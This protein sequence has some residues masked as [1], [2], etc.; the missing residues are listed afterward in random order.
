[1][2]TGGGSGIGL[3]LARHFASLNWD[4]AICG[5]DEKTLKSSA[6]LLMK[7]FRVEC[8]WEVA[9]VSHELEMQHFANSVE[10]K[11]G[12]VDLVV[13][14]AAV[15]GPIGGLIDI[16]LDELRKA[17]E[18][19]VIGQMITIRSFWSAM[20]VAA[21]PRAIVVSGGGL[22]ANSQLNNALGYVPSKAALAIVVELL[23]PEFKGIDGAIVSVAPSGVIPTNFLKGVKDVGKELAGELLFEQSVQ[24][25]SGSIDELLVGFESLIEFLTTEEG[26]TFNGRLLS[27]KWNPVSELIV[28]AQNGIGESRY[29]LRRIDEQLFGS[30]S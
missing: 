5:R 17:L 15:I 26:K 23:A 13:C 21:S 14:N 18:I 7:D 27:A 19:N 6:E 4:V 25:G 11:F 28:E 1:V 29:Q 12:K 22:G 3:H 30:I 20:S 16:S 10:Q 8:L 2:I 9:D 24:Q